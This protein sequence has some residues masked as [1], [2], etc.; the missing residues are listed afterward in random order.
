YPRSG[1]H[2]LIPRPRRGRAQKMAGALLV[3]CLAGLCVLGTPAAL[4]T[5][6]LLGHFLALHAG[7]LAQ[8][9]CGLAEELC[10]VQARYQGSYR[11]AARSCLGGSVRLGSLLLLCVYFYVTLCPELDLPLALTLECLCQLLNLILG[12]QPLTPAEISEV[13]ERRHLNVAQG[14]AWSYYVGYLKLILPGLR[15]RV[16][17]SPGWAE[18]APGGLASW[19]LHIL[20]PLHCDV[21]DDLQGADP[22]VRFLRHL[23]D[24]LLDRAGV[25]R[26]VYKN[27][28]YEIWD[29]GRRA[30]TCVLEYATPL[31]TLLAMSRDGRAGL[32]REDRLEQAKLFCRTLDQILQDCPD[33]RDCCRLVVYHEPEVDG[34][35]GS[36]LAQEILRHL[37]QQQTEEFAVD[38][39]P[40]E[41]TGPPTPTSLSQEPHFLISTSLEQPMTLLPSDS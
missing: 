11:R 25:K 1:L 7:R 36:P 16:L 5:P 24:L 34:E 41:I 28:L 26:R 27:S 2:P 8:R 22:A 10:H 4:A 40:E 3:L 15:E 37:Q 23:P 30:G 21:R 39:G 18:R 32:S 20:L 6:R 19:R 17:S 9:I 35:A 12:L 31:Q 13:C 38:G 29:R 14:L 33:C